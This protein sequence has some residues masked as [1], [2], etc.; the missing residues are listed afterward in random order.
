MGSTIQRQP[1]QWRDTTRA[2]EFRRQ[3]FSPRSECK[4][5]AM[6]PATLTLR[7]INDFEAQGHHVFHWIRGREVRGTRG[8]RRYCGVWRMPGI[9]NPFSERHNSA[10]CESCPGQPP[11]WGRHRVGPQACSVHHFKYH[12]CSSTEQ[13][14]SKSLRVVKPG[15][16][17]FEEHRNYEMSPGLLIVLEDPASFIIR[18]VLLAFLEILLFLT[19]KTRM[20]IILPLETPEGSR[21]SSNRS[22]HL[23]CRVHLNNAGSNGICRNF[24]APSFQASGC[25]KP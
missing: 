16:R 17:A 22:F 19:S 25:P 10:D 20:I 9:L 4:L 18:V 15:A 2:V 13:G 3:F 5:Y 6:G 11:S 23:P 24:Q 21:V 14:P 8:K 12:T 7:M 1:R